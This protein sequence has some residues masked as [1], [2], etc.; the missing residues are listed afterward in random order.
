MDNGSFDHLVMT[1]KAIEVTKLARAFNFPV[2][3]VGIHV[4]VFERFVSWGS[5]AMR[6]H[7]IYLEESDR[8]QG[9]LSA[10]SGVRRYPTPANFIHKVVC[11]HSES[12]VAKKTQFLLQHFE[13]E[14]ATGWLVTI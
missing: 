1:G 8:L 14:I 4:D 11:A 10:A 7:G 9:L 3:R 6:Q 5:Q 2:G 13:N 12:S